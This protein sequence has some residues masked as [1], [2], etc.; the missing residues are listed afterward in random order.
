MFLSTVDPN[1]DDIPTVVPMNQS[2]PIHLLPPILPASMSFTE[3]LNRLQNFVQV[4]VQNSPIEPPKKPNQLKPNLI[5]RKANDRPQIRRE[6]E[7]LLI[8]HLIAQRKQ[9][10]TLFVKGLSRDLNITDRYGTFI[11]LCKKLGVT[12]K[13]CSIKRILQQATGLDVEFY[14]MDEKNL[15]MT[16]ANINYVWSNQLFTLAD[17]Q[18]PWKICIRDSMTYFYAQMWFAAIKLKEQNRLHQCKLTEHGM[19]VQRT[20]NSVERVVLSEQQ[21]MEYIQSDQP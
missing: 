4:Q 13:R 11:E 12:V 3:E 10:K 15:I 20:P 19:I 2:N 9:A 8:R 18:Y 7:A 1:W 16:Q 14:R 21:L 17:D 6:P 5:K